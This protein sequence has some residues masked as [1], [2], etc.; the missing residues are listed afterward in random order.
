[1][2]SDPIR[3]K[4]IPAALS[5]IF[6]DTVGVPMIVACLAV[7]KLLLHFYFNALSYYGY[8]RD[9]LYFIDA[10]K[11]LD[12]GYVDVGPLTIWMGRLSRELMGDSVF[13]LRVFPAIAGALTI[14]IVGLMVWE[15]GGGRFAQGLAG[16]AVLVAP[17]W[18]RRTTCACRRRNL[19]G[20]GDALISSSASSRPATRGSGSG[21]G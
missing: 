1:M 19:F 12:W 21:L 10:G 20:G 6:S 9:E 7:L 16:L 8:L 2:S 3:S 11:H 18:L 17:I 4:G 5:G 14:V 15:L 13:A